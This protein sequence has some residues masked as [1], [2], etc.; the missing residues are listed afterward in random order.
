MGTE[1]SEL[2]AQ[3]ADELGNELDA[4]RATA[5]V[6]AEQ[7]KG[8]AR[9][10]TDAC[11]KISVLCAVYERE[12]EEGKFN[13]ETMDSEETKQLVFRYLARARGIVD[14]L[15]QQATSTMLAAEGMST[16][17]NRATEIV[18]KKATAARAES[19]PVHPGNPV[20]ARRDSSKRA[21]RGRA[22]SAKDS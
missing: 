13:P 7:Q 16:A 3:M 5:K 18:K 6:S 15:S 21:A 19:V 4:M 1:K 9:A 11:A 20:A 10:L 12:V 22:K 2:K 17:Y 8:A 14:N